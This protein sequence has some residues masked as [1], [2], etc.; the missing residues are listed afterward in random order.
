MNI[1]LRALPSFLIQTDTL[2]NT[3]DAVDN[4]LRDISLGR[5]FKAALSVLLA[6]LLVTAIQS[7][8]NW[9][10]EKVP[11]Q[12]RLVIKQSI[13][14]LKGLILLGVIAYM[15]RLFLNVSQQNL[16]ALT[17]T[18][19]VALGFAFKDYV[20][21]IIAGVVALFE[22]PY[23]VGDRVT[24]SDH[25]G[26]VVSYGLRGIRLQTFDDDLVTIPH[27]VTWSD[28]IVNSNSG[29]LEAQVVTDVYV[30]HEADL[31]AI[32]D[33]LYQAAYSSRFIQLKLPVKVV[34]RETPWG[35]HLK[36]RAYPMDIR[37]EPAFRTDILR[38]AKAAMAEQAI[39][40]PRVKPM[41]GL[42]D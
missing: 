10:S 31:S 42:D 32:T 40:Y 9:L 15:V 39:V 18:L 33:I 7:L 23:R 19:A 17:G 24:I 11:R 8:T 38:R 4:L 13:P 3:E 22:A 28:P 21:S 12:F 29:R 6:Y 26:E 1:S 20:T 36:L 30:D 34:M 5:L 41:M 25:Y 37:D 35:T 16:L 2:R 14:F 27:S